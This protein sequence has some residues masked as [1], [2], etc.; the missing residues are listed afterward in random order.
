MREPKEE[1]TPYDGWPVSE[2]SGPVWEDRCQHPPESYV[3]SY[4]FVR[5][6]VDGWHYCDLYIFDDCEVCIRIGNEPQEYYSPGPLADFLPRAFMDERYKGAY[7]LMRRKGRIMW[8]LT[9][10]GQAT[11]LIGK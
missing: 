7:Y 5:H 8:K 4:Q 2:I 6:P 11:N 3:G 9:E 1:I 10:K